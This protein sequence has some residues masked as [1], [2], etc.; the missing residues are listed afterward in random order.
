MKISRAQPVFSTRCLAACLL[1]CVA[2]VA[3]AQQPMEGVGITERLGESLP[4]ETAWRDDTGRA[5]KLGDYFADGK[6]VLLNIVYYSCPGVC[7]AELNGLTIALNGAK[8]LKVGRDFRLVT[9]SFNPAEQPELAA[10]K[11]RNYLQQLD[12]PIDAKDWVFLTGDAESIDA[13]TRAAGFAYKRVPESGEFSH[14]VALMVATPDGRLSRYLRGVFYEPKTLRLA[15]VEA[16]NGEIGTLWE[17]VWVQLCG[18]DPQGGVYVM[19]APKI[20]AAGGAFTLV[21][22]ALGLGVLWLYEFRKRRRR[23]AVT[24][25]RV[26]HD[27]VH[28]HPA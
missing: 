16:S 2:S 24:K 17:G 20:L 4:L 27:D 23:G 15:M 14:D 22:L 21:V 28:T 10:S 25:T 1:L 6:P 13:V 26:A 5:V 18:Y 8:N 7:T 11:K 3:A 19:A 12:E 9:L